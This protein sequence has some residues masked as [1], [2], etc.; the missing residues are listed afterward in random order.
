M[1]SKYDNFS[2]R[3]K[4]EK[5]ELNSGDNERRGMV[6][7]RSD[8]FIAFK[9]KSAENKLMRIKISPGKI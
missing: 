6:K 4:K 1:Y 7:L 2:F 8:C 9:N 5:N 3:K